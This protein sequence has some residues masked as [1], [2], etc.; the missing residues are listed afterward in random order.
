MQRAKRSIPH[1]HNHCS[2]PLA[3]HNPVVTHV[4]PTARRR[5][6]TLSVAL[7]NPV[8]VLVSPTA[9]RRRHT[10]SVALHNPVVAQHD[11]ETPSPH[12]LCRIAQP[13][14]RACLSD[15]VTVVVYQTVKPIIGNGMVLITAHYTSPLSSSGKPCLIPL[16]TVFS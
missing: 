14:G 15:D 7:H 12:P 1:Q 4:T 16:S 6:H 8:V 9:S 3:L 5:R 11:G 13:S 2:V 10:L